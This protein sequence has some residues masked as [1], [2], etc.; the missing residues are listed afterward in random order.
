M[1]EETKKSRHVWVGV[2]KTRA[3]RQVSTGLMGEKKLFDIRV[4]C[5]LDV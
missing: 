5:H 2:D 3:K 4:L 1:N